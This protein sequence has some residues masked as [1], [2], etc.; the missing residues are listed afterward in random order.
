MQKRLTKSQRAEIKQ[1]VITQLVRLSDP[2][3]GADDELRLEVFDR[4][5]A[6]LR[7]PVGY[8]IRHPSQWGRDRNSYLRPTA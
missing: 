8:V 6:I 3:G 4:L 7:I 5:A 2:N 1:F